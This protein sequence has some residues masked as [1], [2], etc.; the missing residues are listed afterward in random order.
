MRNE[1][2]EFGDCRDTMRKWAAEGV[3]VQTCV[4]SP[5]YFGLRDYGHDGQIGLEQKPDE[6]VAKLV[7]VF[8]CVRD[9]L[10][11]DGTVWLNMGDS[12]AR[13]VG[14]V[15]EQSRHWDGRDR[16]PGAMHA[17]RHVDN[18]PGYK[19]KDLIGIPWMLAFALRADGWYLRQDIIWH[20]PN[21]MPESVRDRCTKA[22]EYIFLLS[23]SERYFFDSDPIREPI[24]PT[25]T[26]Y[27]QAR[28]RT[29]SGALGGQNKNN[30]ETRAYSEIKGANRR[31]VWTVNTKSYK[32]AHFATFP[33]DLIEPCI[34]AGSR[35]GDTV[36]DPFMG[37]GT[38]AAVAIKHGRKY[39]GC[40]LNP[41][42]KPLQD[43]RIK[44]AEAEVSQKNLFKHA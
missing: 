44:N 6:Y 17:T 14:K 30:F 37:S 38:T 8:R 3:R 26:G 35:A 2:I 18:M 43:E 19:P 41:E 39:R 27:I 25:N 23:K 7:E 31:S 15:S 16:D 21:P 36:L 13:Q 5:P 34:L 11:D 12:Y 22:H 29:A 10:A 9:V 42:Y 28:A 40:E 20:K 32:G 1:M 24:K 4:T 33:P